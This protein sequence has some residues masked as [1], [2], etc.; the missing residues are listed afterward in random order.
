MNAHRVV[1]GLMI[2]IGCSG[3]AVAQYGNTA[4]GTGALASNTTGSNNSAFGGDALN[5]NTI[6]NFNTANGYQAMLLNYS[7][8]DNTAVGYYAL[9]YTNGTNN[10][11]IGDRAGLWVTGSNNIHIGHPGI[12]HDNNVIRIGKQSVQKFTAIAGISGVNVTGGAAVVVNKTGQLGVE[13]SSIRYK[14]DVHS[15][16]TSSERLLKLRPVTFRY[17]QAD[18]DGSNPEHYGLIAEE[19]AKIMPELVIYNDKGQ[20][21]T[22]AYQTLAPLLVNE[23]QREHSQLQQ[24]H[25]ELVSMRTQRAEVEALRAEVGE[26]RRLTADLAAERGRTGGQ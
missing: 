11:A 13:L 25:S 4:Y 12:T 18:E 15:I 5:S 26:L 14:K 17:R 24:E 1:L 19:V 16:G 8:S 2:A 21:E 22:V 7:G 9:Y 6:G 20:P 3:T 10:I 23:L